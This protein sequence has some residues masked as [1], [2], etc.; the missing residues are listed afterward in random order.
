MRLSDAIRLGAMWSPQGYLELAAKDGGTCALGAAALAMGVDPAAHEAM[1][2]AVLEVRW[3]VLDDPARCPA[4]SRLKSA[5]RRF[6]QEEVY[7]ED[8]II[9][10]NDDH[11]WSR[12]RIAQWVE[13]IERVKYAHHREVIASIDAALGEA[14]P[15]PT[16][17]P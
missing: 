1:R 6:R 2:Y 3:P 11:K 17:K 13:A 10:L 4:C 5:W 15:V 9:H 12:E 8:V 14:Q 16:A 7:V